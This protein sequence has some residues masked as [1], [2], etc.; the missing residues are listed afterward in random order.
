[1]PSAA[2]WYSDLLGLPLGTASHEDTIY[3]LPMDH[4]P[5]VALDAN[6]PFTSDGPPR[7]F[8]WADDLEAVRQHVIAL[9]ADGVGDIVDIGSVAFL[10]FRD[11]DGNRLMVCERRL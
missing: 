2:R 9:G 8:W 4:A 1:M 10:H 7:F 6:A 11:P 3:D 5:G